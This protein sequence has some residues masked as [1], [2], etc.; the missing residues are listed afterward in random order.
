MKHTYFALRARVLL[1]NGSCVAS[2]LLMEN[3]APKILA[4]ER[5]EVTGDRRKLRNEKFMIGTA[6][7]ICLV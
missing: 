7:R 2:S 1:A 3:R 4:P 6:D 5:E